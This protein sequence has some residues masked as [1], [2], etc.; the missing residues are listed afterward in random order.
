MKEIPVGATLTNEVKVEKHMLACSV[1]SGTIEVYA[2]PMMIALIEGT[3]HACIAPY[4]DEDE[5]SVGTLVHVSH[6]A[7]T[8]EGMCVSATATVTSVNGR[9]V[10]FAVI[11]RDEAGD[12][13]SGT[14][15]RFVVQTERFLT[16]T[17]AK[18]R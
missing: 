9:A 10:E 5:T 7:A 12:I 16:K 11:A 6:S 2:T 13:G 14:H 4:L 1:G 3:A 18:L 17:K 15:A 8:P